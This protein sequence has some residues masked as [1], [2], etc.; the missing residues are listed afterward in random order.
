MRNTAEKVK[1]G[2]WD[3]VWAERGLRGSQPPMT[4]AHDQQE[5]PFQGPPCKALSSGCQPAAA[6]VTGN[7][8]TW[9]SVRRV[10]RRRESKREN[11]DHR[12]FSYRVE[13]SS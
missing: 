4:K 9:H 11:Q 6:K 1:Q 3:G 7:L 10:G 5:R 13:E 2:K 8:Q 12:R